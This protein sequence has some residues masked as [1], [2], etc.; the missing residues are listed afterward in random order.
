[1]KEIDEPVDEFEPVPKKGHHGKRHDKN[2]RMRG[3]EVFEMPRDANGLLLI[4]QR[5]SMRS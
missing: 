1:V 5:T 4:I 2:D 3:D